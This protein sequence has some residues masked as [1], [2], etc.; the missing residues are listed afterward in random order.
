M[1]PISSNPC[2]VAPKERLMHTK[3]LNV[4]ARSNHGIAELTWESG[5]LAM[6]SH[7][8]LKPPLGSSD[9]LE[10]IVHQ[11]TCRKKNPSSPRHDQPPP[12]SS[13]R[14]RPL[15]STGGIVDRSRARLQCPGNNC[16]VKKRK[17]S[18]SEPVHVVKKYMGNGVGGGTTREER[19]IC[20]SASAAI[21]R[22]DDVTMM[23]WPSFESPVSFKTKTTDEDDSASHSGSVHDFSLF[24]IHALWTFT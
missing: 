16:L 18:D 1:H 4:Y 9:T 15:S 23:T 11:A 8:S 24:A 21:C 10:S 14:T 13:H 6:H 19:S 20:G 5:Q 12:P 7:G 17:R 3:S 2:S 22:D